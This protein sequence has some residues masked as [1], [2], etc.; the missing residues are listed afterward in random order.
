MARPQQRY[1]GVRQ[2]HWGSW[3]SEIRHPLLKTRIWLGTF[4]TAEDAALAYDEAAR[5]MC[6]PRVRTNFP[7]DASAGA[8]ADGQASSSL[9]SPALVAKLHRFNLASV[10]AAQAR[11]KQDASTTAASAPAVQ[12][13]ATIPT[14]NAGMGIAPSPSV[15]AAEWSGGFLEEQY[16]D[17]MIEELLDSNFSM[18]ISY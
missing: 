5:I 15:A 16:V 14:G 13:R 7:H 18:E 1:R 12:P 2:R 6:G 17:Q 9:L 8:G 11:G 10:Q 4:E 3:V